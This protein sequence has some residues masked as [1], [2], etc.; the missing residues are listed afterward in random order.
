VS[1]KRY[2]VGRWSLVVKAINNVRIFI[3]SNAV[4]KR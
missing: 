1:M 2:F 3:I 4:L